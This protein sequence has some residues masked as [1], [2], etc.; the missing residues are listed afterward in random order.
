M[1]KCKKWSELRSSKAFPRSI[2]HVSVIKYFILF[3]P[4]SFILSWKKTLLAVRE[5]AEER[6][7]KMLKLKL[8][9]TLKTPAVKWMWEQEN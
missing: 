8:L 9:Q 1:W 6:K 4:G 2:I 7:S 3:L 5:P